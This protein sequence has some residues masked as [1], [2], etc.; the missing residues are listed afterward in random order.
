MNTK[1]LPVEDTYLSRMAQEV[2]VSDQRLT[3]SQLAFRDM[4]SEE[5]IRYLEKEAEHGQE[6][7]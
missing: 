3:A 1:Q 7:R 6:R 5:F 4:T 2:L